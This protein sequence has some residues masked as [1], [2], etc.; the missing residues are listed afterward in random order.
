MAF[1]VGKKSKMRMNS[2]AVWMTLLFR[3]ETDVRVRFG[4]IADSQERRLIL[5][6]Y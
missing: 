6:E 2:F 4:R 5:T 3:F 1:M